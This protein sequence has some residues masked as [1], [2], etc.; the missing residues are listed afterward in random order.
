MIYHRHDY[1]RLSDN[2]REVNDTSIKELLKK[3]SNG[4]IQLNREEKTKI[5]KYERDKRLENKRKIRKR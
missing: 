4:K 2:Q 1:D 3:Q 5:Q